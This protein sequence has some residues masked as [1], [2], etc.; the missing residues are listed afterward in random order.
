MLLCLNGVSFI[1]SPNIEIEAYHVLN[2]VLDSGNKLVN[3]KKT[4]PLT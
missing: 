4:K 3:Q 1:H 2:I